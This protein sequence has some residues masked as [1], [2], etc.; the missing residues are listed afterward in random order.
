VYH[1]DA[2]FIGLGLAIAFMASVGL[3]LL[4]FLSLSLVLTIVGGSVLCLAAVL[5]AVAAVQMPRPP[6]LPPDC[7]GGLE[8]SHLSVRAVFRLD[9]DVLAYFNVPAPGEG[10]EHQ[11]YLFFMWSCSTARTAA[12]F[13]EQLTDWQSAGAALKVQVEPPRRGSAVLLDDADRALPLPGLSP[14][15]RPWAA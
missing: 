12:R 8:V 14:T 2:R 9:R 15:A 4:G 1:R 7:F 3:L 5:G 11:G 10:Q 6:R 13:A